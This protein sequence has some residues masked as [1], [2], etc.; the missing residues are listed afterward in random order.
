MSPA[1]I[2]MFYGS[3][4]FETAIQ[5]IAATTVDSDQ[6][7][8]A[9]FETSVPA[10][11]VDFTNLRPV[12]SMFDLAQT[13]TRHALM[14]LH[15]FVTDLSKRPRLTFEEVD[16]VPTQIVTEYLLKVFGGGGVAHGLL[17]PSSIARGTNIV[18]AVPNDRCVEMDEGWRDE[19]LRLGLDRN[20][21]ETVPL[22]KQRV[23][24][25]VAVPTQ[26]SKG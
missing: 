20:T 14:F 13:Q 1:G 21:I 8:C 2:P 11:V 7:T 9:W 26:D 16:Y 3:I 10:T 4:D 5:E 18:L 12:P 24:E 23:I 22:P 17:F 19:S 15:S 25:E 6:A